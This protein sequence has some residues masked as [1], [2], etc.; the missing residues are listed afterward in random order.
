M[1][2]WPDCMPR[3]TSPSRSSLRLLQGELRTL[4]DISLQA[5]SVLPHTMA[6]CTWIRDYPNQ[7][8]IVE[9]QA[10]EEH[11][12]RFTSCCVWPSGGVGGAIK[13]HKHVLVMCLVQTEVILV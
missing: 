10:L 9:G 5:D 13:H 8:Q 6:S 12:V 4:S 11:R 1:D 2:L 7:V 3:L